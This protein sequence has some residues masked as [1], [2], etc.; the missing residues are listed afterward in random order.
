MIQITTSRG[1]SGCEGSHGIREYTHCRRKGSLQGGKVSWLEDEQGDSSEG[2]M[3]R[4]MRSR[5]RGSH[6]HQTSHTSPAP[7]RLIPAE[8]SP[9]IFKPSLQNKRSL[10]VDSR[11]VV[12]PHGE[13]M[14]NPVSTQG[15]KEHMKIGPTI[16]E[17]DSKPRGYG[18]SGQRQII[19]RQD[20]GIE[21]L[22]SNLSAIP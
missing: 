2:G 7:L 22:A 20:S 10:S 21:T 19:K 4:V 12:L 14:I 6:Y 3:V 18:S 11:H 5:D 13:K 15:R 1:K 8:Q 17:R 9:L 16:I